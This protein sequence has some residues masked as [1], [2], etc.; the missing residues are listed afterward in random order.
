MKKSAEKPLR[1]GKTADLSKEISDLKEELSIQR[2]V[3]FAEGLFQGDV[4]LRT[5]LESLA[6]GVVIIDTTGAIVLVN[7]Q[8]EK[9]FGYRREE[10]AGHPLN[11]LLPR[12][13]HAAHQKNVKKYFKRPRI[14]PMGLGREF[15]A[16]HKDGHEFPVEISLS[17]LE[18]TSGSLAMAFVTDIS[19]RKEAENVLQSRNE[20]LDAFAHTVAHDLKGYLTAL[21]GYSELLNQPG[22]EFEEQKIRE[23]FNEICRAGRK[24]SKVIDE[25]LFLAKVRMEDVIVTPL[26]MPSIVREAIS[27]LSHECEKYKAEI[28]L[29]EDFPAALGHAPWVEEVWYNY[30][31]NAIKH[32]GTPPKI[33][34]GGELRDDGYARFWVKDNGP[35]LPRAEQKRL[36]THCP[37]RKGGSGGH[38]LGLS[39]VKRIVEKLDGEVG[40]QSNV[41][42]GSIFSFS[43]P[44]AK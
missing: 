11:T 26:D 28:V 5:F 13:F 39:I 2:R 15:T 35:G 44:T 43:L 8:V 9:L 18:T 23:L 16:R 41:N 1:K 24:M 33:H 36:F 4:T 42:E 31:S 3:A 29:P 32:G 21:I 17:H 30:I 6:E 12:R 37:S 14:R 22:V 20:E 38:G 19:L 10:I 7:K 27:R 34:I 40:V 25:L